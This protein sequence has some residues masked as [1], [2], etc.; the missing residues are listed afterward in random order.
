MTWRRRKC[1]SLFSNKA[2]AKLDG[3]TIKMYVS[4]SVCQVYVCVIPTHLPYRP[5]SP[6][7]ENRH[8]MGP[9]RSH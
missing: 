6:A 5:S 1:R 3:R 7:P 4:V 9:T 2:A 8:L